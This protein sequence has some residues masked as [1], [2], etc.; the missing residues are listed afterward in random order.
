MEQEDRDRLTR[1][2]TK[3]DMVMPHIEKI[4]SH[5]TDISFIKRLTIGV[6]IFATTLAGIFYTKH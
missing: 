6:W 3:L 2:E 5:E 4:Q 1:I